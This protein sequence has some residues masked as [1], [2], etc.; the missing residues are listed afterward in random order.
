ME[1]VISSDRFFSI[2]TVKDKDLITKK[3]TTELLEKLR[4]DSHNEVK[5]KLDELKEKASKT[6]EANEILSEISKHLSKGNYLSNMKALD[7]LNSKYDLP[8]YQNSSKCYV[9]ESLNFV[10]STQNEKII[11]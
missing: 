8:Y 6:S 2:K 9:F 10:F 7:L 4:T 1:K 5:T 11:I 3:K